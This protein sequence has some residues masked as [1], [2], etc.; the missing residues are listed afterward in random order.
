MCFDS[1]LITFESILN[2][3]SLIEGNVHS[4]T[5]PPSLLLKVPSVLL[6]ISLLLYKSGSGATLVRS[7]LCQVPAADNTDNNNNLNMGQNEIYLIDCSNSFQDFP[8]PTCIGSSHHHKY[9]EME[10]SYAPVILRTLMIAEVKEDQGKV[11]NPIKP[12]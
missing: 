8:N 1:I 10:P 9:Q 3:L 6:D 11:K 5:L 4:Y 7:A 2:F 12:V